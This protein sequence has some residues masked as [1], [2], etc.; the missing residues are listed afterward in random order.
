[1]RP[2]HKISALQNAIEGNILTPIEEQSLRECVEDYRVLY[3][4]GNGFKIGLQEIIKAFEI[5]FDDVAFMTGQRRANAIALLVKAGAKGY[6]ARPHPV[7][8]LHPTDERNAEN[9]RVPVSEDEI[10]EAS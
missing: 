9:F 4:L 7:P 1:M 8:E 2:Y 5:I 10:R 6:T 3:R